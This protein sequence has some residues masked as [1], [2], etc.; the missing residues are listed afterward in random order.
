[1]VGSFSS[2]ESSFTDGSV[3][4][5]SGSIT[6]GAGGFLFFSAVALLAGFCG[7]GDPLNGD[8]GLSGR[9]G[10]ESFG[11]SGV[12]TLTPTDGL[13]ISVATSLLAAGAAC[14]TSIVGDDLPA[15]EDTDDSTERCLFVWS[16]GG[17]LGGAKIE[18]HT[19]TT[20]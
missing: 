19:S 1:M 13:G 2:A 12:N 18:Q 9:A 16:G 17:G 8:T 10:G 4:L 7:A 20:L 14:G 6:S 15:D 11:E 3:A 5:F